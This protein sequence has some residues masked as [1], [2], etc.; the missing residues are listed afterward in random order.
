MFHEGARGKVLAGVNTLANAVKVT[1]GPR[2]R[3]VIIERGFGAPLVA[4]SGVIVAKEIVVEDPF[5]NMGAQMVREV[6]SRTS[7]VAGDG[8][9]TATTLAQAMV[10]EG[11]KHVTAGMNPMDIKRGVD[12]A[13]G[14]V[15]AELK[16]LAKPCGTTREIAQ[17]AAISA[18]NDASVGTLIAAAMDKVGKDG[19]VTVE[20]GSGL[21]S[22]LETVEGLQFDRGYL[23]PYFIN[24]AERR[25]V[26]LDDPFLLVCDKKI[27][28]IRE[29][30]P[31]LE[32]VVKQ[33]KPLLIIAEDIDGDALAT[34][35]VNAV[36]GAFKVCAVKAP[37]FGDHRKALL[38]DI[39][40]VT[41][42]TVV[43]DE[44]GMSL[45]RIT[46]EHLGRARRVEVDKDDTTIVGGH[47]NPHAI[48]E[49]V[50]GLRKE[51]EAARNDFDRKQLNERLAKLSGGVA[52]I[53]VGGATETEM[54]ERTIRIQ[55][56]LHATRA[57]VEEGI[58]P[59]GGVALI[60]ARTA[61]DA[62]HGANTDQDAGVAIVRRAL[63]EPLRQIVT[64]AGADP[65]VIVHQVENGTGGYG[66]NAA[67]ETFGDMVE[68]GV[69]D[70][71]KV[72]RS[73]LQNAASIAG[74]I[75]T[76]DCVI[77]K[78]K[79]AHADAEPVSELY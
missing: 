44:A 41:G 75:L 25:A 52:V 59:G 48:A 3:N 23:S 5:E 55:D 61:L 7:D 32:L 12:L 53:K 11:M 39:G 9:T 50:A 8:T 68:M 30:L 18:N 35:V 4:N 51:I 47:G 26:V 73:A 29:F 54:K 1:L 66:Y 63:E 65:S 22:E 67:S 77:A 46:L 20:D 79:P 74:L 78:P 21:S 38:Q 45:E 24:D 56:A 70:P 37:G 27:S 69:I 62:L 13:T 14:A 43:T 72:T 36:R 2:G 60:R 31:L 28:G 71:A 19:A 76:T 10:Q 40:I 64:N 17:V 34:L 15:V 16:R 58:I 33:D 49:R 42:A 6:A 57:A